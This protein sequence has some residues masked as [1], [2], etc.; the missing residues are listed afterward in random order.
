MKKMSKDEIIVR[1]NK[2]LYYYYQSEKETIKNDEE[3]EDLELDIRAGEIVL[4]FY[5]DTNKD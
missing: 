5:Q 3:K 1:F 2:L 4:S